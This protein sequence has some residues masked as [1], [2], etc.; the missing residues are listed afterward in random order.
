MLDI[1]NLVGQSSPGNEGI[2]SGIDIP[3]VVG[4]TCPAHPL[5]YLEPHQARRPRQ[6]ATGRAGS[7]GI[8]VLGK[9]EFR[10]ADKAL[11]RKITSQPTVRRIAHGFSK[12]LCYRPMI[13][14]EKTDNLVL[15][16]QRPAQL[17][18]PILA[19]V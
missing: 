17:V 3:L 8:F 16:N 7:R 6:S 13:V 5:P 15:G 4:T 2:A 18:I 11:V 9:D 12:P 1:G 14:F 10:A 19:L